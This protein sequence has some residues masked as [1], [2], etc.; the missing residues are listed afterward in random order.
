MELWESG[1]IKTMGQVT[2]E[3][4]TAQREN[5]RSLQKVPASV[6]TDQCTLCRDYLRGRVHCLGLAKLTFLMSR[7]GKVRTDQEWGRAHR[8]VVCSEESSKDLTLI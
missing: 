1:E 8:M 3:R 7:N 4:I 6:C 2:G 5:S